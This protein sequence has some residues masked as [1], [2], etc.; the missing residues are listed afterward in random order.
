MLFFHDIQTWKTCRDFFIHGVKSC[1]LASIFLS[2]SWPHIQYV[3]ISRHQL[4]VCC[5]EL[6]TIEPQG[7][8]SS[9]KGIGLGGIPIKSKIQIVFCANNSFGPA[10]QQS[11][12]ITQIRVE[13]PLCT[14][15]RLI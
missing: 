3:P 8:G 13:G 12:S 9:G 6:P 11:W 5:F 1:K 15:P 14:G 4:R 7:V 10:C 2:L